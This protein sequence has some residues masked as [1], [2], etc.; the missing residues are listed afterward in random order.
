[1]SSGYRG[2]TCPWPTCREPLFKVL[3][4][5]PDV[6]IWENVGERFNRRGRC[7]KG[8]PVRGSCVLDALTGK[9]RYRTR[10]VRASKSEVVPVVRWPVTPGRRSGSRIAIDLPLLAVASSRPMSEVGVD[11][12]RSSS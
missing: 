7:D 6:L 10:T 5:L 12:L 8:R 2:L 11:W 3:K 4:R 9:V 1:M